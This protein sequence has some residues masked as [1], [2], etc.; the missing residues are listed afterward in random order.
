MLPKYDGRNR[1][2]IYG[3][4]EDT[5]MVQGVT[6]TLTTV[7]TAAQREGI[8]STPIKDPLTGV[9][10]PNNQIPATRI[11]SIN[12]TIL[13]KWVPL[14]NNGTGTLN[15][16]A[17][18]PATL[19][20]LYSNWRIDQRV[21]SEDS[22]FGHYLFNDTSYNWAKT[23]PTDGTADDTRG[24]NVVVHWT[25]IFGPR[26]LNDLHAGYSRFF[27]NEY[28]IREGKEDVAS[29]LGIKGL[30]SCRAAGASRRRM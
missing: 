26:M 29:E 17:N 7:P 13:Q 22:I 24:Q 18:F 19:G 3:A 14:P 1:T 25:H 15:W 30:A 5:R 20:G 21:S 23:F 4:V 2:F 8:F 12:N 16:Y 27:E 10:F 9:P 28:E 11:S 6:P